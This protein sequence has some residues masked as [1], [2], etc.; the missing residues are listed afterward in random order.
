MCD[1]LHIHILSYNVHT[2][3]ASF[4]TAAAG[5]THS[6][7]DDRSTKGVNG[8]QKYSNNANSG[9]KSLLKIALDYGQGWGR[10]GKHCQREIK[11]SGAWQTKK[12]KKDT[13]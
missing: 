3:S 9:R 8:Q 12:K 13:S 5:R 1:L 4:A 2:S 10:R 7:G 6:G 11:L